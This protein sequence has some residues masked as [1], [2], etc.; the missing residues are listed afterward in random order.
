MPDKKILIIDDDTQITDTL[1][2]LFTETGAKVTIA[3]SYDQGL[4]A[5]KDGHPDVAVVDV[6]LGTQSGLDLVKAA[7]ALPEP[8]PIFAVLTNSIN[9]EHIAEAMESNVTTFIQKAD[10]DPHEIVEIVKKRISE[11]KK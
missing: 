4:A 10:H 6:M 5:I 2:K 1:Q 8:H 3:N 11:L 9:A 7:Q